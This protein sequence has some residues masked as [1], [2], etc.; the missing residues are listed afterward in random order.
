MTGVR[1]EKDS[2]GIA[3]SQRPTTTP[4]R[5]YRPGSSFSGVERSSVTVED[6]PELTAVMIGFRHG[7]AVARTRIEGAETTT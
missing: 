7:Q 6:R 1:F 3:L 2:T 5:V 4:S